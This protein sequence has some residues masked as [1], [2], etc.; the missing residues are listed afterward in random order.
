MC[1]YPKL[2]RNRKYTSNKKNG[3]NIPPI[4]DPRVAYVPIG[5]QNCIECR[6]QKARSWQIRLLEDIKTHTNGKFI[7]LT[8]NN[9]SIT[10]LTNYHKQYPE[11]KGY[12]LDNSIATVAMRRFNERWRKHHGTALR[13]WA[14]TELGHQGTQNIHL[15]AIIWTNQ[16][17]ETVEKIW[18]YG[19]IWKGKI[20]NYKLTNYVNQQTAT[21]ITKYVHKMDTDHTQYKPIIL[22]SPGIG[23]NYTKRHDYKRNIFNGKHTIETYRTTTGHKISLPIYWRNH[24]YT[25]QQRETLWTQRLDKN[26]RWI[27]GTRVDVST[28]ETEYYKLLKWFQDRNTELGYGNDTKDWNKKKYE[29]QIRHLKQNERIQNTKRLAGEAVKQKGSGL[30]NNTRPNKNNKDD[31]SRSERQSLNKNEQKI[32]IGSNYWIITDTGIRS[33]N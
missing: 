30:K 18:Q 24:L 25:E 19:F 17:L 13:H 31:R 16:K 11:I 15:H 12:A 2:I 28:G 7:T 32:L 21:Y 27:M 6:K 22:T 3:G 23:K 20:I 1:L 10:E 5:C 9:K 29:E 26:E 14:V 33:L 4:K 8:F